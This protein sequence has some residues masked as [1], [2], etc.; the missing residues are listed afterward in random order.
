MKTKSTAY[1]TEIDTRVGGC[2]ARHT[3]AILFGCLLCLCFCSHQLPAAN[4]TSGYIQVFHNPDGETFQNLSGT[5]FT[6]SGLFQDEGVAE[7]AMCTECPVGFSLD[8]SGFIFGGEEFNGGSATIGSQHFPAVDWGSMF[9]PIYSYINIK[10]G[11]PIILTGPGVYTTTFSFTGG[12]CGMVNEL[13]GPCDVN[14]PVLVGV[15]TATVNISQNPDGSFNTVWSRY[16]FT[17]PTCIPPPSSMVAWYPF[18]QPASVTGVQNDLAKGNTATTHGTLSIAGEVSK[19]LLFNGRNNYV[20]APAQ[21]WLNLDTSDFSIDTWVKVANP[22]D[23]KGVAVL[24]D[25]RDSST[26]G[27]H[28]FLYNGQLGLQLA[29]SS[30]YSN[31][32]STTAV[33]A[34]NQWHLVAVTVARNSHKGGVWYL[35]GL[36]IDSR[37]DPTGHAGSL[38]SAAPLDIGVRSAGQGGG[39][40]FRGGLDE[41]EIFNRALGA[42]EVLSLAQAGP[43]GKCKCVAPPNDM[44]AWYA[45]DQTGTVQNDLAKGN[46][47]T[48]YASLSIAGKVANALQFNGAGAYVQAPEQSWLN[49]G[50]GDL[51]IDAW[52]K[53]A[54]PADYNGVVAILDK[55]DSFP[56]RGYHF[57]LYNGRLGLQLADSAGYSNYVSTGVVPADNQWHLVAVTVVRNSP[58]GG[59]WYLDGVPVGSPFDPTG[60]A[61]SLDSAVPLE[62]GSVNGGSSF[63]KGGLDELEI[64]S[65][66]LSLTE[67]QSLY[68]ASSAGKCK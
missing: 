29:D 30:G 2:I 47:A 59:V 65:R 6:V 24:L 66:A 32:V 25:K 14:L 58:T 63:F 64:F 42:S 27:Y 20:E 17:P 49:L 10:G 23:Y 36:P 44:V 31:Y 60:H 1:D 21:S 9:A 50:T 51:S 38:N 52:V 3:K 34:D 12:F 62:I 33:P 55:R 37:F 41:M 26:R 11:P 45:F 7:F 5:G 18:D 48:A 4:V 19:G 57:F 56:V 67:V 16:T 68:R 15:G 54:S 35:D 40:F 39:G 13:Y 22:G 53:V 8:V 61:G 43:A 46:T 28:F